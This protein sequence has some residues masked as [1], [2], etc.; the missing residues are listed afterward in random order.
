MR[1]HF[2]IV[3][4]YHHVCVT[5]DVAPPAM[6][7]PA[8]YFHSNADILGLGSIVL[9]CAECCQIVL[10]EAKFCYQRSARII[11]RM[12]RLTKPAKMSPWKKVYTIAHNIHT[13]NDTPEKGTFLTNLPFQ[14]NSNAYLNF[15]KSP[16][17]WF[18]T[19]QCIYIFG[20]SN[21]R[22]LWLFL[23][24]NDGSYPVCMSTNKCRDRLR[25]SHSWG[26]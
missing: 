6:Q 11:C 7:F 13:A 16:A 25:S 2:K 9:G 14:T 10:N 12:K 5:A 22:L 17:N 21:R 15:R 1:L 4:K 23:S 8:S 18:Q 20:L 26:I 3:K 24:W 19:V